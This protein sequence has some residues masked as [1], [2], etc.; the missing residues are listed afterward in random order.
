MNPAGGSAGKLVDL[1]GA[2]GWRAGGALVSR[3]H[4]NFVMNDHG[5]SARDVRELMERVRG[6]VWDLHGVWLETELRAWP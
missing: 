6:R 3:R 1:A 2:K 5:A 4:A